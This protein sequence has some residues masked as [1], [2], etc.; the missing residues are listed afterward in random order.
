MLQHTD[1]LLQS[2]NSLGSLNKA[3]DYLRNIT[4][5]DLSSNNIKDIGETVMEII[6]KS[7][8]HLDIR[9][10][11][12]KEIP[13]I[14]AKAKNMTKLW[15]SNNPY[16]CNCDMILMKDWLM[17]RKTVVDKENVNCS[18]HKMKG[19]RKQFSIYFI[20]TTKEVNQH[21]TKFNVKTRMHSSRMRIGRSLTICL[22]QLWGGRDPQKNKK[23]KSKKK[24]KKKKLRKKWGCLLWGYLP[25]PPRSRPPRADTP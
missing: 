8:K 7:V 5:L 11:N 22:S 25:P 6:I 3:P 13:R 4:L 15:I 18:G 20:S 2:G 16:E 24:F 17:D 21:S 12:L 19:E 10:N 9:G 1:W 14:I 23:S